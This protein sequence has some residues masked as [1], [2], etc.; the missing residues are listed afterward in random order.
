MLTSRA[1]SL[2]ERLFLNDLD[3]AFLAVKH[4]QF[5]PT[6]SQPNVHLKYE[7]WRETKSFSFLLLFVLRSSVKWWTSDEW[8]WKK[9]R[10]WE[11][12]FA[13][14]FRL[15]FFFRALQWVCIMLDDVYGPRNTINWLLMEHLSIDCLHVLIKKSNFLFT[16][17]NCNLQ[18]KS[19]G[20][21][22]GSGVGLYVN[23][24]KLLSNSKHSF[25]FNH[26]CRLR[27]LQ[28]NTQFAISFAQVKR[29]M[30]SSLLTKI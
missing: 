27:F 13:C 11:M 29:Q 22:R 5:F 19:L 2:V 6:Q 14:K 9:R 26:I 28:S 8:V 4:S 1:A 20:R 16:E 21:H 12:S 15:D 24:V 10:R 3:A 23:H 7:M 17:W 25:L 30:N 18:S